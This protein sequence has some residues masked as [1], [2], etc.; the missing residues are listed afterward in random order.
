MLSDEFLTALERADKTKLALRVRSV[1]RFWLSRLLS[2]SRAIR[3]RDVRL[4]KIG[5]ALG[6]EP[7]RIFTVGNPDNQEIARTIR[8][9]LQG[10]SRDHV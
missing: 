2:V 4:L 1:D 8:T 5:Q 3:G 6:L 7:G 9:A 10:P